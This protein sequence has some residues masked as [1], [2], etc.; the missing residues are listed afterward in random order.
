MFH[1]VFTLVLSIKI[2]NND[3]ED[4]FPVF[5]RDRPVKVCWVLNDIHAWQGT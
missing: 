5:T 2:I 4:D 3:C 1:V